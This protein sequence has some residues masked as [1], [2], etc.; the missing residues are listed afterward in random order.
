MNEKYA[1]IIGNTEYLDPGL[2]QLTT[3]SRD[4]EDLARVFQDREI[5]A[6]DEVKILLNQSEHVVRRTIE[7]FF[8][9]KKPDD[10][11]LLYFSG[12]GVRDEQG[13]LYLAVKNTNRARL[14]STAIK[15][16]YIREAMDQSR[17]KRQVL[18]LDC[19]HSG[20]FAQGTK[21]ATGASIG[22]AS[23]FEAGYG[24][25]VLTASDSTQFAWEGDKVIGETDNSLFTHFLVQGLE[26]E[27]D[28]DGDGIITIDE[29]Y[30][31]AYDQVKISTPNQTPSKF[32]SKQQG[33]IILR[34]MNR[35]EHVKPMP[36]PEQLIREIES[37]YPE[38]RLTAVQQLAN[39]LKGKN[40]GLAR[41]AREQLERLAKED[42]SRRVALAAAQRLEPIRQQ[43]LREPTKPEKITAGFVRDTSR[44]PQPEY[45]PFHQAEQA[46]VIRE[47][48]ESER[49][50][51]EE[52]ERL[53][54]VYTVSNTVPQEIQKVSQDSTAPIAAE[55]VKRQQADN[56]ARISLLLALLSLVLIPC[57]TIFTVIPALISIYYGFRGL[58][59]S[60][61]V[62]AVGGLVLAFAACFFAVLVVILFGYQILF[63]D[64]TFSP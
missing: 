11:V 53:S 60:R 40:L 16:D 33:E 17:S 58:R 56:E 27:A 63:V 6:F 39:L 8:N 19:C 37:P 34:Q 26:G 50:A 24:R 46:R 38:L 41:S 64:P 23:E 3:P 47:K 10:L 61:Q 12:H 20:A 15:S 5:C 36:L 1:L 54:R 21:A 14:R 51:K 22:I 18:I 29:L 4:A 59:S 49:K 55:K 48:M 43:E 25:I 35:I 32:S 30:D 31:Y 9:Q 13:S 44:K 2:A 7:D 62:E 45:D 57:I 28:R 52:A 42:D